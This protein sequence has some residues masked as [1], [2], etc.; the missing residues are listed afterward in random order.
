MPLKITQFS[1]FSS[2]AL[3]FSLK[4][5]NLI[6]LFQIHRR[7]S[8][9]IVTFKLHFVATTV[10]E[11]LAREIQLED[12]FYLAYR[13][14]FSPTETHTSEIKMRSKSTEISTIHIL[15]TYFQV[16]CGK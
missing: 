8:L 16:Y 10:N 15:V 2:R 5:Q 4:K 13:I 1:E 7:R 9:I 3:N 11:R 6:F 12:F 14:Y